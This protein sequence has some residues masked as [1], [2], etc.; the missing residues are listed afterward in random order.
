[1]A[2]DRIQ[3]LLVDDHQMF[4][5]ML[6]QRLAQEPDMHVVGVAPD[7]ARGVA[8]CLEH[9][10]KVVL[11]DFDMPD[12]SGVEVLDAIKQALPETRVLMLTGADDRD[13]VL[14]ALRRGASGYL[15]KKQSVSQIVEAVRSA[16]RGEPV[17]GAGA[18]R[19]LME[20]VTGGA[21]PPRSP[22]RREEAP[23]ISAREAEV[24]AHLCEGKT[25][26]E[27]AVLMT[28]SENTVKAHISNLLRKFGARDRLQLVL[29]AREFGL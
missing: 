15:S 7:G 6:A 18:L 5:E 24:L 26:A 17:V 21:Q 3:V 23:S 16:Q 12:M 27:M 29:H 2:D 11:L 1:M 22:G 14:D 25:N 8:A 19:V 10:P 20:E 13:R 28:V 9:R 4:G